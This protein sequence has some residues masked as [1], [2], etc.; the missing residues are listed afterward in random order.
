MHK[1]YLLFAVLLLPAI[2]AAASLEF[3]NAV[4]RETPPGAQTMVAYMKIINND[5]KTRTITDVSSPEF[6]KIEMHESIV[7]NDVARMQAIKKLSI[8]A[9]AFIELKPGGKHLMLIQPEKHFL[10]GEIIVLH[11]TEA[12]G[13]EHTLAVPVKKMEHAIEHHHHE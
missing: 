1:L 2:S 3:D 10:E 9:N 8:P 6:D 11:F 7:E 5:N 12:D 13:T 4:I